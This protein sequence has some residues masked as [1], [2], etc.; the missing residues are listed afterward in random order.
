MLADALSIVTGTLRD[1]RFAVLQWACV[2]QSPAKNASL[3]SR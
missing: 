3:I 2:Q 1:R